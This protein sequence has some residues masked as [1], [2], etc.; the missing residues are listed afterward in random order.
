MR[1]VCKWCG[2]PLDSDDPDDFCGK[3]CMVVAKMRAEDLDVRKA[4]LEEAAAWLEKQPVD[5]HNEA[6]AR[7]IRALADVDPPRS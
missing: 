2:I 1:K 3:T 7:G 5:E 4:A 6:L